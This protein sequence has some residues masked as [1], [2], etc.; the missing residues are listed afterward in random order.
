MFRKIKFYDTVVKAK[1]G[2]DR[3]N[4]LITRTGWVE[5]SKNDR[6]LNPDFLPCKGRITEM[7]L[8]LTAEKYENTEGITFYAPQVFL[9]I[10]SQ[11]ILE[12]KPSYTF[13]RMTNN[14]NAREV[15]ELSE[16]FI[17]CFDEFEAFRGYVN[18]EGQKGA[19]ETKYLKE[20]GVKRDEIG[21]IKKGK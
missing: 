10:K 1:Y 21:N 18:S 14:A 17:K 12:E 3:T 19:L 4:E 9:E 15:H 6:K 13:Y 16:R 5:D 11:P 20:I 2:F 7:L 8:P